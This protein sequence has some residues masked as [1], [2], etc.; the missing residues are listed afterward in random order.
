[1][2]FK[3]RVD[4]ILKKKSL[5]RTDLSKKLGLSQSTFNGYF[6]PGK[7][8]ALA[9]YL[10][11]LMDLFP[12]I[13]RDWLFFGE[14]KPFLEEKE[15]YTHIADTLYDLLRLLP[16]EPAKVAA[17]GGISMQQLDS[18]LARHEPPDLL[19]LSAWIRH[20]RLNANFLL[21][22]FG[23]PFIGD[24]DMETPDRFLL[25]RKMREER[26]D[27][28]EWELEDD[29]ADVPYPQRSMLDS[30][31][32][33]RVFMADYQ[34]LEGRHAAAG[35]KIAELQAQLL[36][37]PSAAQDTTKLMQELLESQREVIHLQKEIIR[38]KD[39]VTVHAEEKA[40]RGTASAAAGRKAAV[41]R[42]NA[43]AVR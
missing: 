41:G 21:A 31:K 28:E 12:D 5:S 33:L 2:N 15:E 7:E 34:R 3:D 40:G 13:S 23:S 43:P 1:M 20:Y 10:W 6:A 22:Q 39:S 19:T 18:L 35:R 36:E 9:P 27:F 17:V 11:K 25:I 42:D 29:E 37:K 32:D 26:G 38:L 24:D 16:D 30:L 4:F 14:G 8:D